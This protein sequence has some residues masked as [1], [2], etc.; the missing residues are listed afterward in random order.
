MNGWTGDM[1]DRMHLDDQMVA[2]V[3]AAAKAPAEAPLPGE[4]AALAAFREVHQ[5]ARR[6]RS[7][8]ARE[9][10]KLLAAAVF[11]G[12]VMVSG[13]ATAAVG[14]VPL[15]HPNS[16]A[17]T[18]ATSHQQQGSDDATDT[19]ETTTTTTTT[20]S[21][22]DN[23]KGSEISQIARDHTLT[24]RAHGAAVCQAASTNNAHPDG[25]C[26][27]GQDN[28]QSDATHGQS[29]ATHGQ[30]TDPGSAAGDHSQGAAHQN[31]TKGK[32]ATAHTQG[33]T[34]RAEHSPAPSTTS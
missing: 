22:T 21:T 29:D 14:H 6:K 23:G 5:P 31:T 4:A 3:L 7:M 28:G 27:A 30:P 18:H 10:V 16:N 34:A 17:N 25:A 24:G 20:T 26:K 2:A 19:D 8:R 1:N 12:V 15:V 32:S 9:N 11:G 33:A 13:V